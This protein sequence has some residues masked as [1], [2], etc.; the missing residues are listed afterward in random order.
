MPKEGQKTVTL[1]KDHYQLAE[2]AAKQEGKSTARFV[3][4]LILENCVEVP[5]S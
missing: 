4:D 2:K 3:T 1:R 5:Q